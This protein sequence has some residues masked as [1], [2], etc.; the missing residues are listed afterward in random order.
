MLRHWVFDGVG[1]GG[2]GMITFTELGHTV[3][4]TPL[5]LGWGGVGMITFTELGHTVDATPLD[6]GWGGVGLG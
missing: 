1:W 6:L 3:D 2:V 4:A 5:G